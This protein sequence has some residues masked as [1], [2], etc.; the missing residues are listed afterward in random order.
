MNVIR[1]LTH[2]PRGWA[3]IEQTPLSERQWVWELSVKLLEQHNML[4][5][6]PQLKKFAWQ[7]P[8]YQQWHAFIHVLDTLRSD[9]LTADA[10][11]AWQLVGSIY[12]HTPDMVIDTKR[13]IHV[14]VGN[15]C[16]NAYSDREAALQKVNLGPPP[17]PEFI[18]RL[19]QQRE[20]AK[21]KRQ[22][23]DEKSS[24]PENPVMHD[25]TNARDMGPRPDAGVNYLS[26]TLDSTYLQ[27]STPS[28]PPS[29]TYTGSTPE[30]DPFWFMNGFDDSQVGNLDHVMDMDPDFMLAQGHSV[31]D[32]ATQPIAWEQWDAWLAESNVIRPLSSVP[33]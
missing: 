14:A 15:L 9:P 28:D 18:L 29:L 26:E 11:K 31:E 7:A 17:T 12:E 19:R 8:Y 20:V 16:L 27:Q 24:R 30:N 10:E 22:A 2:H 25:Q 5:S 6:N 13:P 21:A 4:L 32:N 23:R 33:N 1:F 3:S